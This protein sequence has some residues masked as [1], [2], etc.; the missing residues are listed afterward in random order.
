MTPVEVISIYNGISQIMGAMVNA[1]KRRDWQHLQA[2]ENECRPLTRTL[3]ESESQVELD[4]ELKREKLDLLRKI[5]ADDTA[6]RHETQPWMDELQQLI[7]ST[8]AQQK[9]NKAYGP[10]MH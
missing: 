3:M 4:P 10:G 2:L 6:I 9:I 5:L 7:R 8:G 1:A